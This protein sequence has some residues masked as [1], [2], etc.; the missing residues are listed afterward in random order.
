MLEENEIDRKVGKNL[1][2]LL[3][4]SLAKSVYEA[5]KEFVSNSYD[6]DAENVWITLDES[7]DTLVLEDDG[8]GMNEEG[9]EDFFRSGDSEKLSNPISGKGRTKI[10]KWGLATV[11]LEYLAKEYVLTTR[12]DNEK[13]IVEES[14][15]DNPGGAIDVPYKVSRYGGNDNGTRI[16]LSELN[17]L[18]K[19]FNMSTL[20]K[21]LL[22]ELPHLTDFNIHLNGEK[23]EKEKLEPTAQYYFDVT[24]PHAGQVTGKF[25]YFSENVPEAGVYVYVNGR[26][27]GDPDYF[28]FERKVSRALIGKIVGEVNADGLHDHIS[29]DRSRFQ[30]DNKAVMNVIK[31][32]YRQLR[33]IKRDTH[34][35]DSE[36]KR[37]KVEKAIPEAIESASKD[38][39]ML[40]LSKLEDALHE[41]ESANNGF[42]ETD[43]RNARP[44]EDSGTNNSGLNF[45]LVDRSPR[46]GLAVYDPDLSQISLNASH[47]YFQI[48]EGAKKDSLR[49]QF[50]YA[51]SSAI[52]RRM[53]EDQSGDS[54][55]VKRLCN[56]RD[57]RITLL[58]SRVLGE[59]GDLLTKLQSSLTL[60]DRKTKINPYRVYTLLEVNNMMDLGIVTAKL[61]TNR[62]TLSS[63]TDNE[64]YFGQDLID[65]AGDME[66]HVFA[67]LL[68]KE[69][70]ANQRTDLTRQRHDQLVKK[71]DEGIHG[72]G[73]DI[74]YLKDVGVSEPLYLV[75]TEQRH[76]FLTL[77]KGGYLKASNRSVLPVHLIRR[78]VDEESIY[79]T[80]PKAE[81][82]LGIGRLE[83][84]SIF[85]KAHGIAREIRTESVDGVQTYNLAD[86]QNVM[87][88][89]E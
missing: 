84:F 70:L 6:A 59:E 35:I 37:K 45:V 71:I 62:G 10:G 21:V 55:L 22:W 7:L 8:S 83:L 5:F 27:V 34:Q 41:R 29:F 58:T 76:K 88:G 4:D 24:L 60:E 23:L 1:R 89:T 53:T 3:V 12:K 80:L 32:V 63:R 33:N 40:S 87:R 15:S 31:E 13:I 85:D 82:Q 72:V 46:H 61:L 47:P 79:L 39:Q 67:H 78:D 81:T 75:E 11:L 14:F 25:Q 48:G 73:E 50:L 16:E 36:K 2:Q 68:V 19:T 56:T 18:G 86:L 17:F 30:E 44:V 9:I 49:L 43:Q 77:Y 20:R 28:D 54:S 38:S 42:G 57:E 64:L 69:Y 51:A 26:A 66:G 65:L 52:A 74:E